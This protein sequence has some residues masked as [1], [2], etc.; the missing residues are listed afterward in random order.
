MMKLKN[1][2]VLESIFAT[3]GNFARGKSPSPKLWSGIEVAAFKDDAPAA[4][5]I[6]AD[7][8][9]GWGWRTLALHA[10]ESMGEK[11]R[12]HV[13]LILG[14]LEEYS[15]PITWATVGHLFLES[16]ARS[17]TGHAHS[18]MPRPLSDGSWSGDWYAHDPCSDV[19]SAPCWYAPD[20]IQQILDCRVRQEIGSHSFSHV[21]FSKQ[22]S[23]PDVIEREL[24]GCLEAMD[25]FGLRPRSLVFPRNSAE[26]S[27]LPLLESAGITAVRH[28][29]RET[30]IR[31]SYPE[32]TSG[33][34]Y[35][36]YESM[37][38]RIARHYG[39]LQKAMIF[40]RKAI[41]RNAVYSLWFHPSDPTEWFEPQ[42]RDILRYIDAERRDGRL[43][44]ATMQDLAAY[45]EARERLQLTT[46]REGRSLIVC[47]RSSLDVSRYGS[48]EVSLLIPASSKPCSAHLE[49]AN[50]EHKPIHVR[51]MTRGVSRLLVNVPAS[52]RAL[53]LTF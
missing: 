15:I 19:R 31:L 35:K 13:P 40:I 42:L 7:F 39:Y 43:W 6:S 49:L 3:Q 46:E 44:V 21:N 34:V 45:C 48:P 27:Y 30:G 24:E 2:A 50:G 23:T 14:L 53:H 25:P 12:R 20:L 28:R 26:Y 18:G 52:A 47:L 38:L 37:N 36:I 51:L 17:G 10:A 9:M 29:D 11:E 41:E 22:C 5:C 8:E 32:R 33:G 1:V 16:C 4:C